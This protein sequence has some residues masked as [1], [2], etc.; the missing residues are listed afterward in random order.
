[1][2]LVLGPATQTRGIWPP[3]KK[4]LGRFP[5][6]GHSGG[7]GSVGRSGSA[8]SPKRSGTLTLG[9]AWEA[10]NLTEPVEAKVSWTG[11]VEM[12]VSWTGPAEMKVSWTGPAAT[13]VSWAGLA[14]ASWTGPTL[15]GARKALILVGARAALTH[16]GARVALPH[17]GA[18]V[19]LPRL[20]GSESRGRSVELDGTS[21]DEDTLGRTSGGN[22]DHLRGD[23]TGGRWRG[24]GTGGRWQGAGT[25][26]RWRGAGTGGRSGSAELNGSSGE[27][28]ELDRTSRG[29]GELD[30]ASGG[31]GELDGASG[32][33]GELDGFPARDWRPP[34]HWVTVS[35]QFRLEVSGSSTGRWY[36]IP[37]RNRVLR[38]PSSRELAR[39]R[40]MKAVA[41]SNVS[42]FAQAS[43]INRARSSIGVGP[44]FCY[45]LTH[46][47]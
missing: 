11:P 10:L 32:G 30:G 8:N 43:E 33:N 1:M 5:S 46:R 44:V 14:E 45:G 28:G 31:I 6:R 22:G 42:G 19:A 18:R 35:S 39:A 36:E 7:A 16:L 41:N 38:T 23:G 27:E 37:S 3:K 12:K 2:A 9:G 34:R 4:F 15:G 40:G 29:I 13:K 17:L 26:G 21:G 47:D 25:G 20:G 24:A